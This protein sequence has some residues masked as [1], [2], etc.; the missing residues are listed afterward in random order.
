MSELFIYCHIALY[1]YNCL[2]KQICWVTQYCSITTPLSLCE[3]GV[4][5]SPSI[6]WTIKLLI[7]STDVLNN[8]S[9]KSKIFLNLI[10]SWLY[11]FSYI[12]FAYFENN[13]DIITDFRSC[14][15]KIWVTAWAKSRQLQVLMQNFTLGIE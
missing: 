2:I 6:V 11:I 14:K 12:F 10:F 5:E 9:S 15:N 7:V 4:T 8:L 1:I 3:I 13:F